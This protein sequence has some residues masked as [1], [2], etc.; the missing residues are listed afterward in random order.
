MI[1]NDLLIRQAFFVNISLKQGN[2][3]LP[4]KLKMKV[5]KV[6]ILLNKLKKNFDMNIQKFN[7]ELIS[8]EFKDLEIKADRTPSEQ[9]RYEEL[10]NEFNIKYQEFLTKE[11]QTEIS[12]LDIFFTESEFEDILE[13]NVDARIEMNGDTMPTIDFME[14][15]YELFVK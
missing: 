4:K 15:F 1:L 6:R 12:D 2:K 3:E 14:I 11:L 9:S 8:Q 10:A 5:F 7:S 13:V